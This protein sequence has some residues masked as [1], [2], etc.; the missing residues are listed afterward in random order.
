MTT[1]SQPISYS[2]TSNSDIINIDLSSLMNTI[3]INNSPNIGNFVTVT[4]SMTQAIGTTSTIN[5]GTTNIYS[6]REFVDTMPSIS[7][8]NDMCEKYPGFKIA[9]EK[10]KNTYNLIKDDYDAEQNKK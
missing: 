1:S 5:W 8:I 6:Y 2:T 3:T 4:P 10:F 9:F 7:K